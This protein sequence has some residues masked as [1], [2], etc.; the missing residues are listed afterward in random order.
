MQKFLETPMCKDRLN[1]RECR[2]AD[3]RY[4][5]GWSAVYEMPLN[6]EIACPFGVPMGFKGFKKAVSN[7]Q[8]GVMVDLP[9]SPEAKAIMRQVEERADSVRPI[10]ESCGSFKG[11]NTADKLNVECEVGA[12]CCGGRLAQANV[13]LGSGF[14]NKRRFPTV[15][16]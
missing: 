6:F 13:Y 1:C 3:D 5:K 4:R 2:S 14:C 16:S 12:K 9:D 8:L 10:C 7:S 11:F 15:Q